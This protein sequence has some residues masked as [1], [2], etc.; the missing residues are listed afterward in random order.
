LTASPANI[1]ELRPGAQEL[2]ARLPPLLAE[3]RRLAGSVV[4]GSHGRRQAGAGEEFWQFRPALPGDE[5]RRIDWRRSARSDA[6]FIRQRE[7]QAA[8]SVLFWIDG[9]QSMRF[10]GASGRDSKG[11]R[12]ALL[13]LA[14]MI[15]LLRGGERVGLIEDGEPPRSG[16]TQ[17]DRICAQ[18]ASRAEGEDY[19]LPAE[20]IF[21]RHS[22][23]VF[24]SDFLGDP[25]RLESVLSGAAARGVSGAL[26]HLL[27]P[28][29]ESFPYDG[30]TEFRSM[31][32]ALRFETLRARGLRD[33]YLE[34]LAALKARLQ[35]AAERAGWRYLCHHTDQPAQPALM[36]LYESL[37]AG[38]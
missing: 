11:A 13:G 30:R 16:E 3:A 20:R 14:A 10:K 25:E 35:A 19:G 17:I 2:A 6:H 12:A 5:W 4:M 33:A 9:A 32:G 15:L 24:L 8:Q 37:E 1:A 38:R 31:A 23:A 22:R 26:V 18:L 21:A 27:D 34:R 29:E 28:L 36:W 7:W